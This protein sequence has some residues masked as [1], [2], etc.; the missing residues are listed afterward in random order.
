MKE[1]EKELNFTFLP[2]LTFESEEAEQEVRA[3]CARASPPE[4]ALRLGE[5]YHDQIASSYL[6]KVSVRRISDEVGYGLFAEERIEAGSYVGEYTGIVHRNNR[7]YI[8]PPNC[9]YYTY[10]IVDEVARNYVINATSGHL[11]RFINHSF[12]PNMKPHYA[13]QGGLY[14]LIFIALFPIEKGEQLFYNYGKKYW[15]VRSPPTKL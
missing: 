14:H 2:H 13:F 11:T 4:E 7:Q 3:K 1:L 6:P 10:P 9:Y 12:A 8:E 5:L 15:Y